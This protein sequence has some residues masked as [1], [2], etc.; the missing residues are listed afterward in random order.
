MSIISGP[1]NSLAT[2]EPF[3]ITLSVDE[4]NGYWST[5]DGATYVSFTN[6]TASIS[7][8]HS[9]TLKYYGKDALN[10]TSETQIKNYF[11]KIIL[12]ADKD[13]ELRQSEPDINFG[14]YLSTKISLNGSEKSH[15][16][17]DFNLAS[18]PAGSTIVDAKLSICNV[19]RNDVSV[20]LN[21]M[22]K[23][24]DEQLVT[25][26][27]PWTTPGGDYNSAVSVNATLVGR[28]LLTE[29]NV[30]TLIQFLYNG[31]YEGCGM[32]IQA[33]NNNTEAQVYTKEG[34]NS[35]PMLTIT[36]KR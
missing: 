23:N 8:D 24:W 13:A 7:I 4:N 5:N 17:I 2:N 36:Y 34:P 33:V 35:Q 9:L 14:D 32:L 26:N 19:C 3:S 30:T 27:S 20:I 16:I 12:P 18:I 29:I 22:L 21:P 28:A 25:W 10:N 11:W 1:T 31:N 15:T 6:G